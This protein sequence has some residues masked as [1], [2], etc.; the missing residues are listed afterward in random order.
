MV[1]KQKGPDEQSGAFCVDLR[2]QCVVNDNVSDSVDE[3]I[4]EVYLCK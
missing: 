4:C 3:K 1:A 2:Y